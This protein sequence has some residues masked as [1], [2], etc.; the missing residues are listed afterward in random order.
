MATS[1]H[2][3]HIFAF[4]IWQAPPGIAAPHQSKQ[5]FQFPT[6]ISMFG[7]WRLLGTHSHIHIHTVGHKK[8]VGIPS[9]NLVRLLSLPMQHMGRHSAWPNLR[10]LRK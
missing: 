10:S 9:F 6:T 2:F 1:T 8:D 5:E 3:H 4:H 7:N